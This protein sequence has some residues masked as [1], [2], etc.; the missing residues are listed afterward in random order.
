P[1]K[2]RVMSAALH[3]LFQ[4]RPM[5]GAVGVGLATHV[6]VLALLALVVRLT[7][8]PLEE[9]TVDVIPLDEEAVRGVAAQIERAAVPTVVAQHGAPPR[10]AEH[11]ADKS[12]EPVKELRSHTRVARAPVSPRPLST[13]AGAEDA[14]E[15]PTHASALLPPGMGERAPATRDPPRELTQA[16]TRGVMGKEA[17]HLKHVAVAEAIQA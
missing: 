3:H 15:S 10:E 2:P 4:R 14:P 16:A 12:S 9:E 6:C 17:A 11:I 8:Q 5:A 1:T 13:P 7:P